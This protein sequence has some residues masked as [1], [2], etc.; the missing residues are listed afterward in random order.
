MDQVMT[1]PT[2][3]RA[4]PTLSTV[5]AKL[6][7]QAVRCIDKHDDYVSATKTLH[8]AF[9]LAKQIMPQR[10]SN[11]NNSPESN[12]GRD[13]ALAAEAAEKVLLQIEEQQNNG[14][15]SIDSSSRKHIAIRRNS[16]I[17]GRRL[18]QHSRSSRSLSSSQHSKHTAVVEAEA[19][20]E[21]SLKRRASGPTTTTRRRSSSSVMSQQ[22]QVNLNDGEQDDFDIPF[23]Y[24]T[25]ID[26][27]LPGGEGH[28]EEYESTSDNVDQGLTN[29]DWDTMAVI[30]MFNLAI[31]QHKRAFVFTERG[32]ESQRKKYLMRALELYKYCIGIEATTSRQAETT[33]DSDYYIQWDC[34]HAVVLLNNIGTIQLEL[35]NKDKAQKLFQRLLSLMLYL[36]ENE[37][38]VDCSEAEWELLLVNATRSLLNNNLFAP[39]A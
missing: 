23:T 28:D 3:T 21:L 31:T 37:A 35:Q 4:P 34:V 19:E 27:I 7:N 11:R 15:P 10:K 36:R 24:L 1:K 12:N 30:L 20:R 9:I 2:T 6:N 18:S 13:Q 17:R 33:G 25:P 16:S 29:A 26:M 8:E 38:D 5:I 14:R 32:N 22:H 39:A